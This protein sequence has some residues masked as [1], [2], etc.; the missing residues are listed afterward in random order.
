MKKFSFD[1]EVV[2]GKLMLKISTSSKIKKVTH[3]SAK[4][5]FWVCEEKILC[6]IL[7]ISAQWSV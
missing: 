3:A 7:G 1:Y 5:S 2:M 4:M 6:G